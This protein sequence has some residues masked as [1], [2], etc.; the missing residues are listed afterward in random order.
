MHREPWPPDPDVIEA[1]RAGDRAAMATILRSGHPRLVG[2][3]RGA[4]PQRADAD[5]L[6][7]HTCEALVKGVTKL[8]DV[9]AFEGWFWTIAR[10]SLKGWIRKHRRETR[11]PPADVAPRQPDEAIEDA[12]DYATIRKALA[13]LSEKDRQILWLREV[14]EL[15]YDDISGRLG[16]TAATIRVASHRARRRLEEAYAEIATEEDMT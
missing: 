5:D 12:E 11:Y 14:E 3:F 13:K 4:G 1:A 10:T 8:R 16:P 6:A 7:A 2:F 15:S 9:E